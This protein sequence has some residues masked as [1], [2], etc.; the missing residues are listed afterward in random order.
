MLQMVRIKV[1]PGLRQD[2]TRRLLPF[3]HS[4]NAQNSC[5][6]DIPQEFKNNLRQQG[7][8]DLVLE[9]DRWQHFLVPNSN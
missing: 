2:L 9:N 3:I 6:P 7:Y 1:K 8:D 4:F 5:L